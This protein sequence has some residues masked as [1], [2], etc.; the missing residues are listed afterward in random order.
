MQADASV[1]CNV[2]CKKYN[3]PYLINITFCYTEDEYTLNCTGM[4]DDCVERDTISLSKEEMETYLEDNFKLLG[5][6]ECRPFS[7]FNEFCPTCNASEE[8]GLSD[9]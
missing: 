1:R 7:E 2:V 3:K 5:E 6:F 4:E 9:L 8:P